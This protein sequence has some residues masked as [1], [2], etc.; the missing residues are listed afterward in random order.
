[1]F[2]YLKNSLT[3]PVNLRQDTFS[4]PVIR[5]IPVT[6]TSTR[7]TLWKRGRG[8]AHRQRAGRALY[9]LSNHKRCTIHTANSAGQGSTEATFGNRQG[10][11]LTG[12]TFGKRLTQGSDFADRHEGSGGRSSRINMRHFYTCADSAFRSIPA[13]AS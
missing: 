10:S 5:N 4:A 3:K 6:L 8:V 2:S 12:I 11:G 9:G 1:M 13:L 7:T